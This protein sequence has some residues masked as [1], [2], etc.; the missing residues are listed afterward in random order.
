MESLLE[1]GEYS[2]LIALHIFPP[3][4]SN[5][6]TID[7]YNW[8]CRQHAI[9]TLRQTK[10]PNT[11]AA[12]GSLAVKTRFIWILEYLQGSACKCVI[13]C[14]LHND[15]DL[16]QYNEIG[17]SNYVTC[18]IKCVIGV[19]SCGVSYHYFLRLL[20]LLID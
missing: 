6:Y 2:V 1:Q 9:P 20:K 5:T 4:I 17:V 3:E 11:T 13:T 8:N 19:V 12:I 18:P 10:W 14:V 15:I 16:Q 7:I